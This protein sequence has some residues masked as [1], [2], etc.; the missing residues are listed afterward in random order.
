MNLKNLDIV[1]EQIVMFEGE[2]EAVVR[3][4]SEGAK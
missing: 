3:A 2:Y 4:K 1:T